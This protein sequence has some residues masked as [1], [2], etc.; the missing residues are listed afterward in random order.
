MKP[1]RQRMT[2]ES[3]DALALQGLTF[4]AA[5]AGRLSRFLTLTGI[6]P[7]QLASWDDNVLLRAA[8]LEH[9]LG[10]ESMLLVFAAEANTPPED[11]VPAHKLLAAETWEE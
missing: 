8:V 9:L 10:D 7:G 11:I 3:A 5:D 2:I 4:L 6:E 1:K